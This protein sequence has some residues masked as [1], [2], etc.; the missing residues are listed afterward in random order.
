MSFELTRLAAKC[1]RLFIELSRWMV[2]NGSA[3]A[4]LVVPKPTRALSCLTIF[5]EGQHGVQG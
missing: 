1:L 2:E 5:D 3:E 4:A